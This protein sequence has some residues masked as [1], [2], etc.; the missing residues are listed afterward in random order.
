MK[1]F[2]IEKRSNSKAWLTMF[3]NWEETNPELLQCQKQIPVVFGEV[4]L[5]MSLTEATQ[6]L[7]V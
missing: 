4:F 1:Y 7:T 2:K 3:S 5:Q 6:S